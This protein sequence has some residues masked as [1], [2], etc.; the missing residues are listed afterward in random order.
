[1]QTVW[2]M[3][4]IVA[5][6]CMLTGCGADRDETGQNKNTVPIGYYSNENHEKERGFFRHEDDNDGP[7][8]EM[9]DHTWGKEG[10][11]PQSPGSRKEQPA[12]F[13]EEDE[14]I[15]YIEKLNA[16]AKSI[17][18]VEDA[19]T[20]VNG[21]RVLL[22]V[23]CK[24]GSRTDKIRSAVEKQVRKSLNGHSLTVVTDKRMFERVKRLE[25]DLRNGRASKQVK[26][27]IENMLRFQK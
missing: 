13:K 23:D 12:S 16:S 8:T 18:G 24:D 27:E 4:L 7:L 17:P 20:I 15:E 14:T 21:N 25:N 11:V 19:A 5:T 26:E 3:F 22:A 10:I 6:I 2:K 1:M 9:M